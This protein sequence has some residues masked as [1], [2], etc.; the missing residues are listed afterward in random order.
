MSE[1][2]N[3]NPQLISYVIIPL[4]IVFA[5]ICD[6]TVG[7]LRIIFVSRGMRYIAPFLGFVEVFVWLIAIS[8]IMQNLT[9]WVNYFAYATGFALGNYVGMTI[10]ERLAMG[11]VAIRI[12]TQKDATNLIDAI[13]EKNFGITSISA[14]GASGNVRLL[15]SIV[16]R[17]DKEKILDLA[18]HYNPGAFISIED[19]RSVM[20]GIFPIG[21]G[22]S[23]TETILDQ[24]LKRK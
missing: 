20:E 11:V 8:Q 16:K 14:T 19:V 1:F 3:L 7:T 18:R 2:L 13:R 12:I 9:N 4:A 6:V 15:F 17:K 21:K 24:S 5:R 23:K 10:E 22:H